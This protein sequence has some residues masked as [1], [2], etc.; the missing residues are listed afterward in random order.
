[1]QCVNDDREIGHHRL[2]AWEKPGTE[3]EN[4]ELDFEIQLTDEYK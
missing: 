2:I 4:P 1:M 3:L